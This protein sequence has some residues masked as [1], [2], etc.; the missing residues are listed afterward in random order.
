MNGQTDAQLL[1]AYAESHSEAAFNELVRR[2]VDLVYSAARRMV[3]GPHLTEDVTQ[4]AFV[5]L[6]KSAGQLL[7]RPVI[8]NCRNRFQR[9]ALEPIV[10]VNKSLG[11]RLVT[12]THNRHLS[13][14][15]FRSSLLRYLLYK[16]S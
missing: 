9:V 3:C 14:I 12:F 11:S 8:S 10:D 2:H 7:N 5:A 6:A 15:N 16:E 4:A 13:T 1:H